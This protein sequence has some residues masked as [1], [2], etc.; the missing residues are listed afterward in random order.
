VVNPRLWH[1]KS[2]PVLLLLFLTVI[3]SFPVPF[4]LQDRLIG[5]S[6]DAWQFPWNNFV[7]REQILHRKDPYYTDFIFFPI[8]T[9]LA[10][11]SYTE[12]N[13]AV[14]LLLSPFLNEV[15]QTNIAILLST[16]LTA[17]GTWLLVR[18]LT[19]NNVAAI[20]AAFAFAFCPFRMIRMMGH[21]NFALTQWIPLA[22]WAFLRLIQ[23][24]QMRYG[25]LLG[26]FFAF[27]HYS[28]QYYSVYL[29]IILTILL[30]L[31]LFSFA[32]WRTPSTVRNLSMVA[33]ITIICL[34]PILVRYYKDYHLGE[35]RSREGERLARET[36]VSLSDYVH[37]GPMNPWL[38]R[39]FPDETVKGPYSKLSPGLVT[40][41]LGLAGFVLA[42]RNKQK[43]FLIFACVGVFFVLLSLG[44]DIRIGQYDLL[45]PYWFLI[46]IPLIG[47]VRLPTRFTI[48]VALACAV[49]AGYAVQCLLQNRSKT[50]L[51]AVTVTG[52][53]LFLE[54]SPAPVF[55]KKFETSSAF[56]KISNTQ[57]ATLLT[58]PFRFDG[59]ASKEIAHQIFHKQKLLTGR[60]SRTPFKF[61]RYFSDIPVARI[62]DRLTKNKPFSENV[63]ERDA[64][65][66]SLFRD[67][68]DV[69]YIAIFPPYDGE[70]ALQIISKLFPDA[71]LLSK[72]NRISVYE[73]PP[74]EK[75]TYEFRSHDEG[76]KFFL[77]HTWEI[78]E[79]KGKRFFV[80]KFPEGKLLLPP[81]KAKMTLE[82][83][84]VSE[85]AYF[86]VQM[87][88]GDSL[89]A[90]GNRLLRA[91]I[92]G[93]QLA[94]THQLLT[95]RFKGPE[96]KA[97]IQ[98]LKLNL[99]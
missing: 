11:H 86:N 80:C 37:I 4:H 1:H 66:A 63:I 44:P 48:V 62:F 15:G 75:K 82:L 90:S 97:G 95:L 6:V 30:V 89:L 16:F 83:K 51:A 10:L 54:L 43:L 61:V 93:E 28:N 29:I 5:G 46:K 40:L 41:I 33:A 25:I 67:F 20:F 36:A 84:F 14:G 68:F 12:F 56:R 2:F 21:V 71:H 69:R 35:L 98:M 19:N 78:D 74:V 87:F 65:M 8:G 85:S 94:Q 17:L 96:K 22:I 73:L 32:E 49:L 64:K 57:N 99:H 79:I 91:E 3:L 76:L 81:T 50:A 13:G 45:L 77:F 38:M 60:I 53:L 18:D 52:A 24:K 9:S 42:I 7:F 70:R 92:S 47:H 72:E 59:M 39:E 27:T 31:G 23:R 55:M 58:L 26:W 34:T 88:S